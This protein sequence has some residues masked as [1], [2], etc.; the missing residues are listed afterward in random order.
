MYVFIIIPKLYFYFILI[1]ELIHRGLTYL[2][3]LGGNLYKDFQANK[4]KS[5]EPLKRVDISRINHM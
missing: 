3:L 4:V 2:N 1:N 5:G